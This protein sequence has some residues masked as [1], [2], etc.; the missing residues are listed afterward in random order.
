MSQE[1]DQYNFPL[2]KR[3]KKAKKKKKKRQLQTRPRYK[4]KEIKVRTGSAAKKADGVKDDINVDPIVLNIGD[5][6]SSFEDLGGFAYTNG[7]IVQ[8]DEIS[9]TVEYT[10]EHMETNQAKVRK[11]SIKPSNLA[12]NVDTKP[13]ERNTSTEEKQDSMLDEVKESDE[14]QERIG[15]EEGGDNE[16]GGTAEAVKLVQKIFDAINPNHNGKLSKKEFKKAIFTN[17]DVGMLLS[18]DETLS[19]LKH[20][21]HLEEPFQSLDTDHDGFV[22]SDELLAFAT[23][24][25]NANN[26]KVD[27][28]KSLETNGEIQTVVDDGN[29][30][31]AI[32]LIQ[33]DAGDQGVLP[34]D[35]TEED[36]EEDPNN[37]MD[38]TDTTTGATSSASYGELFRS[39]IRSKLR[40][41]R[42]A[43][44]EKVYEEFWKN[45]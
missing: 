7:V 24:L 1:E 36:A 13:P 40:L 33:N 38:P 22:S 11:S 10:D 12:T 35:A 34:S 6:L 39:V 42:K 4:R 23:T 17:P 15:K 28:V 19:I 44:P 41:K 37:H 32:D 30:E 31:E 27:D 25:N 5:R 18:S 45:Y 21:M 16:S 20:P 2:E 3:I 8:V 14:G 9:Y 26:D 43:G 29:D